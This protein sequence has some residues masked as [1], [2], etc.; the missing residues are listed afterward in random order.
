[1]DA[2]FCIEAL[3]EALDRG[4]VRRR[5]STPIR[6]ARSPPQRFT[7][8]L[9][10]AGVRISMDGRGRWMDNVFIER[11]WRSLKYEC[12]Y[13]PYAFETGGEARTGI[14]RWID[15]YNP[16]ASA[17]G[18]GRQDARRGLCYRN[19]AGEFG[20]LKPPGPP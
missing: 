3:Q 13:I 15:F 18:A 8:V 7:G 5:S 4:S 9:A 6:A 20:G 14:G 1:M 12:V 16:A 2:N 11:L 17:L 19:P 10:Q